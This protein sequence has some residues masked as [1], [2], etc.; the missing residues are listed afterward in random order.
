MLWPQCRAG[1]ALCAAWAPVQTTRSGQICRNA[2]P[3]RRPSLRW[4]RQNRP[5]FA[6]VDCASCRVHA[7]QCTK[8]RA[9]RRAQ[10][11]A[12]P[13]QA[14]SRRR[15]VS[16]RP[17]DAS[18]KTRTPALFRMSVRRANAG[19]LAGGLQLQLR[20]RDVDT[21]TASRRC[22]AH[23]VPRAPRRGVCACSRGRSQAAPS[24]AESCCSRSRCCCSACRGATQ[25][26]TASPRQAPAADR[27]PTTQFCCA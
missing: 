18:R 5:I 19:V 20:V 9:S 22:R 23:A 1:A 7:E 16:H 8:L 12:A 2:H 27:L 24:C 26:S 21:E 25:D 13:S 4:H 14:R 17:P 15:P 11:C 6:P 3:T 10:R